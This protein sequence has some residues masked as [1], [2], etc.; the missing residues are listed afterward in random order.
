[1]GIASSGTEFCFKNRLQESSEWRATKEAADLF[2]L[3]GHYRE[4]VLAHFLQVKL[5]QVH[6]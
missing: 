4:L 5:N 1:L 6:K 2:D 3:E